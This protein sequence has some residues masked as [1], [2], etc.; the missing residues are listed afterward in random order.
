MRFSL[1]CFLFFLFLEVFAQ[2]TSQDIEQKLLRI[3]GEVPLDFNSV[4]IEQGVPTELKYACISLS[5]CENI[6]AL[7]RGRE[8]FF[9]M[10][11]RVAK[12]H[13]LHISNYVDER[14]DVP[15]AAK[16]FC[17]EISSIYSKTQDW[18][19][20]ITIYSCGDEQWN[21]ARILS[22]DTA[23]DYWQISKFLPHEA[24]SE[25]PKYVAAVYLG[26]FYSDYGITA[27]SLA[28]DLEQVPV[29]EYTTLYQISTRLGI[30]LKLLQELN[31]IY[32]RN[33]VPSSEKAYLLT[34]PSSQASEFNNLGTEVYNY[35]KLPTYTSTEV[36]VIDNGTSSQPA[37]T[38]QIRDTVYLNTGELIDEDDGTD[39]V[40]YFVRSGD[41]LLK[42]ADLF[43]CEVVQIMRW[44]NLDG[45]DIDIN[46]KLMIK[47]PLER[48]SYYKKIDKMTNAQRAM[49]LKND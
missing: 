32:K 46:Q 2:S 15:K 30:T 39:H 12:S 38:I 22:K 21:K 19:S 14:R 41:I 29:L 35:A 1:I 48:K 26:N 18:R 23:N 47:V 5:N 20:A 28:L 16:A 27:N 17:K 13:G 37:R 43:D 40:V 11:Y 49:I 6:Q 36:K 24:R 45:D 7:T 10:S 33:I 44:N 3:Q 4:F 25:Y 31:P 34:L 42:I 8:G 9:K